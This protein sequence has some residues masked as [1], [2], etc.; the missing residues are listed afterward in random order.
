MTT[1]REV[2]HDW[3]RRRGLTTVFGNP[4]S[5]ELTLLKEFPSDFRYVLGLQEAV[6][7]GMADGYAAVT[8]RPALVNL[9]TAPGVGNA[10]GAI[11]SAA[12]NRSPLIVTAGQQVRAMQTMEALLTNVAATTLPQPAVKWSFEPPRPQDVPAALERAYHVA[13]AP[14]RG[15]VFVSLPMDDLDAPAEGPQAIRAVASA[16]APDPVALAEVA[17]RI[18]QARSPVLVV[19]GDVDASGGWMAAVELAERCGL[20]V[21]EAPL[22]GRV[23]FPQTH[24]HYRGALLPGI[25]LLSQQLAG[26]DLVIVAGAP[27]FRYYPYVPGAF[28]PDGADLVHLTADPSEAARA[29]VGD[30]V[31]GDV[32]LALEGLA[33]LAKSREQPP[34]GH[35]PAP[36]PVPP[37]A[38]GPMSP[39]TA[40]AAIAAGAPADAVWVNESPSNRPSFHDQ[41]RL[42][43]PGSFLF[44]TGGGLGFGLPAAVGAQ[45]GKPSRPVIAVVGDGSLQYAVPALWSAAAYRIPLTVVVLSNGGYAIL[46]WFSRF[47]DAPGVPGLDIAGIDAVSL[48]KGYGLAATRADTAA[49]LTLAVSLSTTSDLPMLIDVPVS[50][51]LPSL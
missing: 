25:G 32:R 41:I 17:A 23:A 14:P 42:D 10:M 3:M 35:W 45:L 29:P 51:E 13:M 48:A 46:K 18:G 33:E 16:A 8:G 19:G 27:V 30:A 26:H 38:G 20:P 11:L 39:V 24:P 2:V 50:T 9:H 6:V 7:V 1:V 47:E 49:A 12:A 37:E 44:T 31:V 36:G 40:L 15:P 43:Q 21:W 4:G 28:L 5:T 22:E 34:P